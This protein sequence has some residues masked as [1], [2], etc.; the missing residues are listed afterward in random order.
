MIDRHVRVLEEDAVA[1][2]LGDVAQGEHE[3]GARV[4]PSKYRMRS[5]FL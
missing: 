4:I 5:S 3:Q 2:S 1:E